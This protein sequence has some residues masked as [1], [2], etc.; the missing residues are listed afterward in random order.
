MTRQQQLA[1]VNN[2]RWRLHQLP[3]QSALMGEP[4]Q[5]QQQQQPQQ[6]ST[7]KTSIFAT[8]QSMGRRMTMTSDPA[9]EGRE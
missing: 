1:I 3:P 7:R 5:Q 6:E 8:R 4:H 9:T 2:P